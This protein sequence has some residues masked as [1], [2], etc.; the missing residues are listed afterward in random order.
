[1]DV[2]ML[3]IDVSKL[4]KDVSKLETVEIDVSKFKSVANMLKFVTNTCDQH[5]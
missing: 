2:L 3:E 1:M 4:E 5:V